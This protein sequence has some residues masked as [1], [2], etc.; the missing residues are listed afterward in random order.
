MTHT[1]RHF[2]ANIADFQALYTVEDLQTR[3]RMSRSGIHRLVR[4]GAL[5]PV[6]LDRR[7][8]F[9]LSDVEQLLEDRKSVVSQSEPGAAEESDECDSGTHDTE[10]RSPNDH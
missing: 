4:S 6:R 8:R 2:Q 3:L 1:P 9:R 5:K 7:L 10:G